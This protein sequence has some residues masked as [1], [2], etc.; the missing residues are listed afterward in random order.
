MWDALKNVLTKNVVD[1]ST[2]GVVDTTDIVKALRNAGIAGAA[3]I[4]TYLVQALPS[5]NFGGFTQLVQV[6]AIPAITWL[7]TLVVKFNKDNSVKTNV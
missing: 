3:A 1:T 7:L 2:K 6:L 4:L 5:M